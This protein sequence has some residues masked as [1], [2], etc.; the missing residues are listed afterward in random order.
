MLV[1][2]HLSGS[3]LGVTLSLDILIIQPSFR[4][5]K[6]AMPIVGKY[7]SYTVVNMTKATTVLTAIL[8]L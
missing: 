3:S 2:F 7:Q 1:G 6:I 4:I 8:I 5:A